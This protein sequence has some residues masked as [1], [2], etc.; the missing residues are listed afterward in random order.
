[1]TLAILIC[2]GCGKTPTPPLPET[3]PVI[4]SVKYTDGSPLPGGLVQFQSEIDSTVT[5]VGQISPAGEYALSTVRT[6]QR[7]EG[8]VPGPNRV[9]VVPPIDPD[10]RAP[11]T[12]PTILPKL[13]IVKPGPNRFDFLI[14]PPS[15][16]QR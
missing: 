5:T 3:H 9:T 8:A 2:C 10:P 16:R 1:L 15:H 12:L 11:A 4:G 14:N 6:G 13:Y 7:S